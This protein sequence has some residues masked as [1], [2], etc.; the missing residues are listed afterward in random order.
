MDL[1]SYDLDLQVK[2]AP[3]CLEEICKQPHIKDFSE[4]QLELYI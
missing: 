1:V 3:I 4:L 2:C